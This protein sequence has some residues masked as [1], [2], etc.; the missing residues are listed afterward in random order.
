MKSKAAAAVILLAI[1][2]A[3]AAV[4]S[5]V[6]S[7]FGPG[8]TQYLTSAVVR[9]TIAQ[10]VVASGSIRSAATY[11]LAFGA[12]PVLELGAPAAGGSGGT[13]WLVRTVRVKTGD[14]VTRGAVLA[15]ADTTAA[16]ASLQLAK[17]GLAAA[18]ARLAVDG[19]GPTAADRAAAYD[20]I[21]QAQ[22]QLDLARQ[23]GSVTSQQST[24]QVRQ[25]EAAGEKRC[26]GGLFAA[27]ASPRPPLFSSSSPVVPA[28]GCQ[29]APPRI[30]LPGPTIR[31]LYAAP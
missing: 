15:T 6:A 23:T 25:A 16:T 12:S 7:P 20:A 3:I 21:L 24:L 4:W 19:A 9:T 28:V 13:A 31:P 29:V 27:C 22:Q 5:V 11:D 30:S 26:E 14:Q 8:P 17:A 10:Q 2:I 1:A 18:K